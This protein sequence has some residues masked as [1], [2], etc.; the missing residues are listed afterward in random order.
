MAEGKSTHVAF[1]AVMVWILNIS[2][3]S[4]I[5]GFLALHEI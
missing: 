1:N 3:K 5:K 4:S 2:Q